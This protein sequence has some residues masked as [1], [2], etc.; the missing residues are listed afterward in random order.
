[1]LRQIK[2]GS[3]AA[4]A[5]AVLV[6]SACSSTAPVS[7]PTPASVTATSAGVLVPKASTVD[8]G[9]VPFDAPAQ[10]QF[11]LMNT[12]TQPVKLLRAPEVTMLEGC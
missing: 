12:G 7:T 6:L 1:M 8:L 9:N 4:G 10:G 11:E 5:L 2:R 3:I